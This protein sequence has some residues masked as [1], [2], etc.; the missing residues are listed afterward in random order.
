MHNGNEP[1]DQ[2]IEGNRV[3]HNRSERSGLAPESQA[4]QDAIDHVLFRC[5]GL[6]DAKG[7]CVEKRLKEML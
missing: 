6:T 5:F 3:L 4:I 2:K 1:G 7:A